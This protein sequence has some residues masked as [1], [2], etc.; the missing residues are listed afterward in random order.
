MLCVFLMISSPYHGELVGPCGR[1]QHYK[2]A[3]SESLSLLE[4]KLS[5]KAHLLKLAHF[6]FSVNDPLCI[7]GFVGPSLCL[8]NSFSSFFSNIFKNMQKSIHI[9]TGLGTGRAVVMI[10][11]S[12]Y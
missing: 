5:N 3:E 9:K 10:C 2:C 12:L 8:L 1:L 11:N 7:L 4:G 6:F